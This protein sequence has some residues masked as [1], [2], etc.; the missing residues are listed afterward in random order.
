M[1]VKRIAR[2]IFGI[3]A[4]LVFLI[5]LITASICYAFIFAFLN[6]KKAPFIAH[7]FISRNWARF[8]FFMYGIRMEIRNG[9]F[10]DPKQTYV[11]IANHRSQLDIPAYA[12]A[13]KHTIRFLAKVEL[14][15]IPLMGFVIRNLYISVDRKDKAARARSMENM[16]QSL[17]EGIS[18]FICPEGTRNKGKEPFLPFHDGAFRLAIQ[19]QLPLAAMVIK[20][21]GELLSPLRPIELSPGKI[22]CEWCKPV[23]TA[24]MTENDLPGLKEQVIRNMITCINSK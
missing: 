22:I 13:T 9:E 3:Y 19:S 2:T 16:M 24:G 14:T 6:K 17:R 7:Q 23:L 18:V 5:G 1:I 15:K 4:L 8:I 20:N 10:L 11:F 21:S 12:I